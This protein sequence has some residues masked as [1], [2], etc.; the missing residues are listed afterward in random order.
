[1]ENPLRPVLKLTL[2]PARLGERLVRRV[3]PGGSK[4]KPLDDV[5]IA[6]KVETT[7]FRGLKV[8]KGKIDVNVADGVVWLRGEARTPAQIKKLEERTSAIEE[9]RG[10]ENLLHLPKTPAPSRTDTPARQRKTQR[11][12][13]RPEAQK[14]TPGRVS[15]EAPAPPVA[16]PAPADL[17]AQGAGR[18]PAPMGSR[19]G[20]GSRHD[21]PDEPGTD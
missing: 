11:S 6:R 5:T 2:T 7:I 12:K 21:E 18:Q 16:E 19:E 15:N 20:V 10:V 4:P 3:L 9:V 14:V 17:A 13:Q 8:D 1:M